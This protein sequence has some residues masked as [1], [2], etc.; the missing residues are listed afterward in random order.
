MDTA[1][2]SYKLN[3]GICTIL[4]EKEENEWL[5]VMQIP[6]KNERNPNKAFYTKSEAEAYAAGQCDR[7][8]KYF[9]DI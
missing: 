3:E 6:Y 2:F 4:Y 7:M 5:I 9:R 8:S 1:P